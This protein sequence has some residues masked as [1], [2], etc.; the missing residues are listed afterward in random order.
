MEMYLPAEIVILAIGVRPEIG[1]AKAAGLAIGTVATE[2]KLMSSI[3]PVM[4]IFMRSAM[5]RKRP[6][7]LDGNATLVPLANLG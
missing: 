5:R 2:S 6:M 3:A 1:L 7:R 4:L